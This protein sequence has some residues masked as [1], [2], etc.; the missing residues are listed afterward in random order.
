MSI[1]YKCDVCGKDSTMTG[2]VF[3]QMPLVT[4]IANY[5]NDKYRVFLNMN[6]IKESDFKLIEKSLSEARNNFDPFGM[7]QPEQ[8]DISNAVPMI[9]NQCKFMMVQNFH[10]RGCVYPRQDLANNIEERKLTDKSHIDERLA[11]LLKEIQRVE[12]KEEATEKKK[13]TSKQ[14]KQTP[15]DSKL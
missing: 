1:I 6:V 15:G 2:C 8:P 14:K 10:N 12:K 3:T 9:C 13:K 5:K 11:S 7:D 4:T